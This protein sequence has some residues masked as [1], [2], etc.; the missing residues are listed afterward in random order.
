MSIS[1][2]KPILDVKNLKVEFATL[3]GSVKAVRGVSFNVKPGEVLAIVGESGCGKSVT[4]QSLM[5]LIP[6]PPGKI[7]EGTAMLDGVDIL[8]IGDKGMEDIRG[9]VM[10]MIFQ[11]PLTSLNPTMTVG[12]QVAEVIIK[13]RK[14]SPAK[15]KE[16]VLELMRLVQIPEVEKRYKQ[17]PHEFSGGMRQ[18]VMIAIALACRPKVLIA[19]EPTTALDVT[20]QGQIL[21]LIRNLREEINMAVV[22]ITHDLGVVAAVADRVAVMY[23]GEIVETGRVEDIFKTPGHP[24]TRGLQEA[25]PNPLLVGQ[26]DLNPIPGSPPDLFAPPEGCAF[27]ARCKFAMEVCKKHAPPTFDVTTGDH[28]QFAACWLQHKSAPAH[29]KGEVHAN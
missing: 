5:G 21:E 1:N 9:A 6:C 14:F 25:I 27:S 18:R 3:G 17:Y 7:T 2:E 13:H 4:C 8:K 11:D 20:I 23:A 29:L 24:Y 10:S 16:E 19:D 26:R 15:A 28:S 22:L 12:S